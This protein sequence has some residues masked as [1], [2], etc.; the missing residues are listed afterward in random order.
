MRGVIK[1]RKY[2]LQ[3]LL[4]GEII[5]S[6]GTGIS[7]FKINHIGH[8]DDSFVA[9]SFILTIII[10]LGTIIALITGKEPTDGDDC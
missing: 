7:F 10:T 9:L 2:T 5:I 1:I 6:Y 3:T 8:P 4:I